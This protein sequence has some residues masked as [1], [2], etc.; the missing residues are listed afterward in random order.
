MQAFEI[1]GVWIVVLVSAVT[2]TG[3]VVE[4]V[5]VAVQPAEVFGNDLPVG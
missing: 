2:V 1:V 4:F 5:L 3:F